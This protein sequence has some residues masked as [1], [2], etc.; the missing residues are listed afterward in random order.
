MYTRIKS[1]LAMSHLKYSFAAVL[2]LAACAQTPETAL[3]VQP[4]EQTVATPLAAP[5]V[6][7]E[8]AKLPDVDLT[9]ELLYQYLL[10][11]F[12]NQRGN[13]SLAAN[14]SEDVAQQTRDPRLAKR[15]AQLALESGDMNKTI[16]A[17][18]LW[19]ETDPSVVMVP[20]VLSSLLLRGGR[21]DEARDEFAK[22]LKAD[23][24]HAAN[25]FMQIYPLAVAYPDKSAVLK[26]IRELAAP[27]PAVAEAHLL[28]AQLAVAVDDEPLALNEVR[29]AKALR[30]EW[31]APVALEAALLV[32]TDP[33]LSLALLSHYLSKH[34]E[35]DAIRLQYARS[36]LAQKQYQAAHD[37]FKRLSKNSPDNIELA[38]AVALISL[39]LN[40]MP[41]AE[42]ELKGATALKGAD[43]VEYFLGQL[44]EA[45]TDEAGALRHYRAVKTGE[46]QFPATLRLID[47]LRKQGKI[48]EAR[49]Q[50]TQAQAVTLA[51]RLQ[52][53]MIDA[54]LLSDAGQYSGAYQVLKQGLLKCPDQPELL[55]DAA[56]VAD[57]LK[58]YAI[59]EK[60]L[61]KLIK[62]KPDFAHAYNA[63]G[64]SL[65]E[66]KVHIKE[67]VSLVEKA[68]VLSPEDP[69]IMDSV[70][71]GYYRS[72]RLLD[73]VAM[74]RR[75]FAANPD[76]EIAGHLGEALWAQGE[77]AEAARVWQDSL[78]AHPDSDPLKAV[79]KRFVP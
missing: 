29:K 42:A 21:L 5:A 45:K 74:L 31:D 53:L 66:R 51:Q 13:K 69:A 20:R 43:A 11:E 55:Y 27:Y 62:V 57:K 73:S 14:T 25:I 49:L 58:Q 37:E 77:K 35:S 23:P 30:A 10:S 15:A 78:K 7:V 63:L 18:R 65:L 40:D 52:A 79:M 54:Q 19:R 16:A 32:K 9:T 41:G 76:P 67:A 48:A 6:L 8:A 44:N 38:F 50:L 36:L 46:Y 70:G 33:A 56:M 28:V 72:G 61:R 12:A 4:P 1:C 71:W 17:F 3:S 22:V 24:D 34:P 26:I 59:S 2:L 60:L 75:A 47:L 68:L 39:Q 64:Y